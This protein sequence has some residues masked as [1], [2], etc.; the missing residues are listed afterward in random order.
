VRARLGEI[1]LPAY[2]CLSPGL[3]DYL[4]TEAA[5]AAGTLKE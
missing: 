3:M 1:G 4:A 5:R 2:D